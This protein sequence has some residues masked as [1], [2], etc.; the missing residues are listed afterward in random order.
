LLS[1]AT[2]VSTADDHQQAL[3]E[4]IPA[5]LGALDG[6]PDLVVCFFSMDHAQAATG[7]GPAL[8]ERTGTANVIGCTAQG[9]IAGAHELEDGPGLV[10]WAASLPGV[11]VEVFGLRLHRLDGEQLAVSGWPSTEPGANST[12]LLLA[13]PFSFPADAFLDRLN[14]QEPTLPVLGGMVSGAMQAGGHRLLAGVGTQDSGAV[15]VM[16]TGPVTVRSVVSQGCRPIGRPLAVTRLEGNLVSELGGRPAVERLKETIEGLDTHDQ[17]LLRLGGL[18]VG[19]VIDEH[20]ADFGRGDF[21]VRQLAGADPDTGAIAVADDVELGATLQFHLRDAEAADDE[22]AVLLAPVATWDPKSVLLFS[23]NG[24]GERFFGSPD[25]DA[26]MVD[27]ATGSVPTAGFFAQGEL[28]PV[29]GRNFAHSY[30][31]SL[32]VFSEPADP[33]PAVTAAEATAGE[34]VDVPLDVEIPATLAGI[35]GVAGEDEPPPREPEPA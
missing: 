15:G 7:I 16:L 12:A 17:A 27:A 3:D 34:D 10:L 22:F 23:C 30:T 26:G 20:K 18:Q 9:V 33:V 35:D 32:A 21:L 4:V 29:G 5:V 25:H 31:A 8:S 2:A 28:G 13:D 6:P 1:F 24:R 19:Q 14:E 11:D